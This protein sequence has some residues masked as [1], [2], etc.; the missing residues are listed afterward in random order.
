M[1]RSRA[2]SVLEVKLGRIVFPDR[3]RN[4]SLCSK[5]IAGFAAGLGQH[6][7]PTGLRQ[8]QGGGQTG[9]SAAHNK[10]ISLNTQHVRGS[11]H[12]ILT[13]WFSIIFSGKRGM[14]TKIFWQSFVTVLEKTVVLS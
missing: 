9:D 10:K 2:Q 14:S 12:E 11:F 8:R 6:D 1:S 7:H 13:F 5:R 3:S 4:P